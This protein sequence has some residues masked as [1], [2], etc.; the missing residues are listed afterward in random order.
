MKEKRS[1]RKRSEDERIEEW[2]KRMK[3]RDGRE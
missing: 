2:N 1:E 3:C